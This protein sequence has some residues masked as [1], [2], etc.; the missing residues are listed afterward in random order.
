[1]KCDRSFK[2]Q[3]AISAQLARHNALMGGLV[4]MGYSREEASKIA[5]RWVTNEEMSPLRVAVEAALKV[6][7]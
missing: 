2:R 5:L 1:M 6:A 7:P 4:G 3:Q